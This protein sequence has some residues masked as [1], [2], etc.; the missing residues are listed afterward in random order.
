MTAAPS[1]RR[2]QHPARAI[3]CP[4][5]NASVGQPCTVPSNRRPLPAPHQARIDALAPAT[6]APAGAWPT[7]NGDAA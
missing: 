3:A 4:H 1:S 5:C 6:P 2:P 7:T